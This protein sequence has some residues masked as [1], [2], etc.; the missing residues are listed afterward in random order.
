MICLP[1]RPDEVH[2]RVA[3]KD[4]IKQKCEN[5]VVRKDSHAKCFQMNPMCLYFRGQ[6]IFSTKYKSTR[7]E[8]LFSLHAV[9][10]AIT[11]TYTR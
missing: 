3:A 7:E 6:L 11:D 5:S 4:R 8:S 10:I 9:I 1:E 2:I